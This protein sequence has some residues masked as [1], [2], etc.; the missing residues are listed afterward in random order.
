[1]NKTSQNCELNSEE[2]LENIDKICRNFEEKSTNIFEIT[3]VLLEKFCG[4]YKLNVCRFRPKF[5][6]ILNKIIQN[7]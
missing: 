3:Y 6:K 7:F 1:M 4:N 5:V 2:I